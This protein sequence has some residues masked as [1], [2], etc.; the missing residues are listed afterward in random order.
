MTCELCR[1]VVEQPDVPH[2]I[3]K[4][5]GCGR[6][7]RVVDPGK[8]GKGI[9]LHKGDQ[10]VIPKGWLKISANPLKGIGHLSRAGLDWFAKLIFVERLL[11]ADP[12]DYA[13][14][15][16]AL[17]DQVDAI[18]NN[19]PLVAPL[20]INDA[21]EANR[22]GE[23]LKD[24]ARTAEFWAFLTGQFLVQ[25]RSARESGDAT[26]ASWASACAERCHAM[27]TFKQHLEEVVW[28]GQSARRI[29]DVLRVWDAN[30]ERGEEDF[31]QETF[32]E[33][34]YVL[35]Q[36]FAVPLVFM[37]DRAYVGG[38]QVDRS[39]AAIGDFLFHAES[40]RQA[41]LIEIK[42]PVTRLLGARYRKGVYRPSADLSGAITQVLVQRRKLLRFLHSPDGSKYE[43]E[44][45]RPRCVVV[46]GNGAAELA[47]PGKRE[48]FELFR[49]SCEVEVVT[50]DELFRK[51]EVLASL[52]GL[53]RTKKVDEANTASEAGT[54]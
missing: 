51:A 42:T 16:E 2:V 39:G 38:I 30:Y 53:S 29:I 3:R 7:M 12:S 54:Q 27:L 46:V 34:S 32:N 4:C 52:F 11:V 21:A 22:I 48:S 45:F 13:A 41:I 33:H 20:D 28:M 14:E 10:F 1:D 31:W 43:I 50:Y 49:A 47:D 37:Q 36:I 35:S 6:E 44:D 18:V 15:A 9:E 19:S 25:A 8:H 40:S 5:R 23:I 17:E 24:Q 26:K